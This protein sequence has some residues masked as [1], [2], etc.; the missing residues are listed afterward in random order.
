MTGSAVQDKKRRGVFKKHRVFFVPVATGWSLLLLLKNTFP[1]LFSSGYC[2]LPSQSICIHQKHQGR[3]WA[4][5]LVELFFLSS[6]KIDF[7]LLFPCT[8]IWLC[9][10]I[11]ACRGE[12]RI[13]IFCQWMV[14]HVAEV[15]LERKERKFCA[16]CHWKRIC[17]SSGRIH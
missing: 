11:C 15:L 17:F 9:S 16:L 4:Y 1:F 8:L 10:N 13:K 5:I 14:L 6:A 7:C 2:F 12:R 3:K